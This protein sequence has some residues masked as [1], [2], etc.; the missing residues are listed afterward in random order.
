[1]GDKSCIQLAVVEIA[2]IGERTSEA[3]KHESSSYPGEEIPERQEHTQDTGRKPENQGHLFSGTLLRQRREDLAL[4]K[5]S[6]YRER[7][8]GEDAL[9][10]PSLDPPLHFSLFHIQSRQGRCSFVETEVRQVGTG[11]ALTPAVVGR[12]AGFR[13]SETGSSVN[14]LPREATPCSPGVS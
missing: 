6:Q 4:G 9:S 12:G 13:T 7:L 5:G 1:M 14:Q 8:R 3:S 10:W 2:V 11:S